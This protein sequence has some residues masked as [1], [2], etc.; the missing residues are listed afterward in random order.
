MSEDDTKTTTES[1][2][3]GAELR[4]N[5]ALT[6]A[7]RAEEEVARAQ[8]EKEA[9]AEKEEKLS[10]KEKRLREKAERVHAEAERER[11]Q[12]VEAE[13]EPAAGT[14]SGA[15][16]ASPGVGATSDP[17][18]QAA[19]R[20]PGSST[21]VSDDAPPAAQRPEVLIGAAFVG[22]FVVARILKR[23]FD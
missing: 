9:A 23:I 20:G 7:R 19:A 11:A 21:Y 16:V 22:S 15:G 12:A 14:V 5:V 2:A 10:R 13:Q 4:E 17:D 1:E 6:D 8:A 18:A 3:R